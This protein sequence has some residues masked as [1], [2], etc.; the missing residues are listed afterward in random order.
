MDQ[1]RLKVEEKFKDTKIYFKNICFT[2]KRNY[3]PPLL[4]IEIWR[5]RKKI[6]DI[7]VSMDVTDDLILALEYLLKKIKGESRDEI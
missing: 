2:L 4:W 5:P 6:Y 1:G 3:N 7:A